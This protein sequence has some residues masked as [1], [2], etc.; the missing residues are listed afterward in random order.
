MRSVPAGPAASLPACQPVGR[1]PASVASPSPSPPRPPQPRYHVC[2]QSEIALNFE[3][4]VTGLRRRGGCGGGGSAN[5]AAA[6]PA[7]VAVSVD[8]AV[9]RSLARS[10][11]RSPRFAL[12]GLRAV[13]ANLPCFLL[14]PIRTRMRARIHA[15]IHP[16]YFSSNYQPAPDSVKVNTR[17]VS[18]FLGLGSGWAYFSTTN[19]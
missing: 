8:R 6:S 14:C 12:G 9:G 1:G 2:L 16:G 17:A 7:F 3:T 13:E 11:A 5:H 18:L 10:L 4:P 15:M 19:Q